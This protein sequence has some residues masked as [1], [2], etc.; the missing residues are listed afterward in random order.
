MKS[1]EIGYNITTHN[2]KLKTENALFRW[3]SDQVTV[4]AKAA[5]KR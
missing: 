4:P 2:P 1:C 5:S 3:K